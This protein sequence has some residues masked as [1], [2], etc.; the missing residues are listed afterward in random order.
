MTA[1]SKHCGHFDVRKI[2][3]FL[4]PQDSIVKKIM[5]DQLYSD[6]RRAEYTCEWFAGPLRKFTRNGKK[7][8]LISGPACSGK[9]VLSRW[10]QEQLQTDN[11][12][13]DPFDVITFSVGMSIHR[14]TCSTEL[15]SYQIPML[16][17]QQ[18]H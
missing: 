11:V 6:S 3:N 16:S 1:A 15:I 18:A 12:D 10:I 13:N 4:T 14:S 8:M 9:T 2:R 7:V 5:S 17:I